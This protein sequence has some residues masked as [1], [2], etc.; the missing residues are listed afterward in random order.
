MGDHIEQGL[1][2]TSNRPGRWQLQGLVRLA[3]EHSLQSSELVG[4]INY[5]ENKD[6]LQGT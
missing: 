2:I 5:Q 1:T 6:I 4:G 3:Y